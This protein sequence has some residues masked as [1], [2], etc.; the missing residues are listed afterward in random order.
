MKFF[1][2]DIYFYVNF[3]FFREKKFVFEIPWNGKKIEEKNL[4]GGGL[5][6]PTYFFTDL[7]VRLN[8]AHT[9]NLSFLG[10]VEVV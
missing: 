9:Q 10:S 3:L 5:V 4:E 2:C 7:L 8:L 6:T 1:L